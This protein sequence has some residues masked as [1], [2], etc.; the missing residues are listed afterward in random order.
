MWPLGLLSLRCGIW[1]TWEGRAPRVD[2]LAKSR[3]A[4]APVE[5]SSADCPV[6]GD[7]PILEEGIAVKCQEHGIIKP[8]EVWQSVNVAHPRNVP[9]RERGLSLPVG[10]LCLRA[11]NLLVLL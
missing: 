8:W 9:S 3:A 2:Q 11:R 1:S 4:E 5:G 6:A 7:K 10:G